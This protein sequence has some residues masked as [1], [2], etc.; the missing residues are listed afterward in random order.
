MEGDSS[1]PLSLHAASSPGAGLSC[2]ETKEGTGGQ[3]AGSMGSTPHPLVGGGG[4]NTTWA[5]QLVTNPKPLLPPRTHS[6]IRTSI[7]SMTGERGL[8]QYQRVVSKSWLCHLGKSLPALL[9]LSFFIHLGERLDTHT[10]KNIIHAVF[11]LQL[12]LLTSIWNTYVQFNEQSWALLFL[13]RDAKLY[14]R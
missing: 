2:W 11:C 4:L 14:K 9:G 7:L 5:C 1:A 6:W 13:T 3:E 8:A 10:R 12:F